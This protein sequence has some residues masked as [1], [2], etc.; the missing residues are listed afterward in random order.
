MTVVALQTQ[1]VFL[2]V[3]VIDAAGST[4]PPA[5]SGSLAG[6]LVEIVLP[7]GVT[8]RAGVH[9]D[10]S[11]WRERVSAPLWRRRADAEHSP[12]R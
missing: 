11:Q 6:M 7:G 5:G 2:P 9:V 12:R 10:E 3:E 8:V 4:G 1:P